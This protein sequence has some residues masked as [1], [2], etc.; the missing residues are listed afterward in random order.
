MSQSSTNAAAILLAGGSGT[1]M[2]TKVSDKILF[3]IQGRSLFRHCLDAFA[4]CPDIR[5]LVV[6]YRDSAQRKALARQLEAI[7]DREILWAQGGNERQFSVWSGLQAVPSAT[8][9][10]LIHDCARPRVTSEAVSKAIAA[11]SAYGAA[12]IARKTTDTIKRV[13]A[14]DVDSDRYIPTT[15]D[16]SALWSMETPQAF[17]LPLIRDAYRKVIDG[18]QA[19]TDD[20]SAIEP[21]GHP[22]VFIDNGRANPKL[23]TP[24][25]IAYLEFLINRTKQ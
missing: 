18:S 14:I 4:S 15:I 10:V 8:D 21:L 23:T 17:Q 9:V 5:S 22:V 2:G 25:D 12:C 13:E 6:V 7:G 1:R 11:A 20:L 16:R 3:E 24:E 19:I